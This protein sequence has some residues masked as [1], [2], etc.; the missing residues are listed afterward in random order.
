M[1]IG[2]IG[3]VHGM[4]HWKVNLNNLLS[5]N[6]DK[7]VF[8]GDYVDSHDETGKG[9]AALRN[10]EEIVDAKIKYPN[11]IDLLVGNHEFDN[12]WFGCNRCSG[13]QLA[14]YEAYH[15]FFVENARKFKIA[16]KYDNWVFSHAGF[17]KSWAENTRYNFMM[18]FGPENPLPEDPV[19]FS[20][21]LL[22]SKNVKPFEFSEY[23]YSTY[24]NHASQGP[25]W[26]RP[27]ALL[28]NSYYENQVVGHTE[29]T[30]EKP[31]F[32]REH[33]TN[34]IIL[35]SPSHSL[36]YILD[37]KNPPQFLSV[38]EN[39][40]IIKAFEKEELRQKSIDGERY[41]QLRKKYNI[42]KTEMSIIKD[43]VKL[44]KDDFTI[45]HPN[46]EFDWWEHI[47]YECEARK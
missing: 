38:Q 19:E 44:Q 41:K 23:D 14:C 8:L 32:I 29:S 13:F 47:E 6:C 35:D 25:L 18:R 33:N 26:I 9:L 24:G 15:R 11:I 27:E 1:K 7:I 31:L 21:L 36:C 20:N 3:D 34:L 40:K 2:I 4:S 43:K 28:K 22:W 16:V 45:R 12:Y 39:N 30:L 37:T 42:S 17:S 10:V 46:D 5:Q